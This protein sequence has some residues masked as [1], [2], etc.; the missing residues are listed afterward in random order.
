VGHQ[1]APAIVDFC[2]GAF[3][4]IQQFTANELPYVFERFHLGV[5]TQEIAGSGLGAGIKKKAPGA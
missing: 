2:G 4:N 5:D 1:T 3:F